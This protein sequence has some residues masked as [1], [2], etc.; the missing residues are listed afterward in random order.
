M[1][2]VLRII[3]IIH[4]TQW[5]L[6]IPINYFIKNGIDEE[7]IYEFIIDEKLKTWLKTNVFRP[8]E[9]DILKISIPEYHVIKTISTQN[10]ITDDYLRWYRE[11]PLDTH[12]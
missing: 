11:I 8:S 9:Y 4:C 3:H 12:T 6:Y 7:N 1:T 5:S 2:D 10:E